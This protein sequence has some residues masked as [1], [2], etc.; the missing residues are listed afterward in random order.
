MVIVV[1]T[2]FGFLTF[3]PSFRHASN[4]CMKLFILAFNLS[5]PSRT[6]ETWLLISGNFL[7]MA[8]IWEDKWGDCDVCPINP[9]KDPYKSNISIPLTNYYQIHENINKMKQLR[10]LIGYPSVPLKFNPTLAIS[11]I[12]GLRWC[13]DFCIHPFFISISVQC[14]MWHVSA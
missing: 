11:D 7:S 10:K 12:D 9:S 14:C 5:I 2:I 6:W 13:L 1:A 4:Y 3:T 8:V